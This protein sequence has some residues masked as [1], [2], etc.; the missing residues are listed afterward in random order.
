VQRP[1]SPIV[2][3]PTLLTV[4]RFQVPIGRVA[5]DRA[6]LAP[7]P[8]SPLADLSRLRPSTRG[9]II[10]P[11]V[12]S[13][14]LSTTT[15][16]NL[17]ANGLDLN[18]RNANGQTMVEV[19]LK[20]IRPETAAFVAALRA[21][22]AD[23]AL[24]DSQGN[25]LLHREVMAGNIA[26]VGILLANRVDVNAFNIT[27]SP[28]V[29]SAY[30]ASPEIVRGTMNK[31]NWI[32]TDIDQATPLHLAVAFSN[33]PALVQILL[34]NGADLNLSNDD[35]CTPLSWAAMFATN[36]EV[37]RVLLR[38]GANVHARG[39]DGAVPLH[40]AAAHSTNPEIINA[41]IEGG[42]QVNAT[43]LA[44]WTS[45]HYAANSSLTPEIIRSL[46]RH[47]ADVR[48]YADRRETPLHLAAAHS[49][50]PQVISALIEGGAQVNATDSEQMTPLHYAAQKSITPG[51]IRSLL[52][53]GANVHAQ[54][55]A[56]ALPLHLAAAD[57]TQPEIINALI[58]IGAQVNATD[59]EG[60]T[61]LHWA[62]S[63]SITPNVIR[64]LLRHGANVH[65]QS[66]AGT[67][68]LHKAAAYST[69][70]EIINIL[71]EGG[72]H[73]NATN[74]EQAT[75]LHFAASNSITPEIIRSLLQH[76]ADVDARTDGGI[77]PLHLAAGVAT[78]PAV[79][80]ALV[81]GGAQINATDLAHWT[82]LHYA[83]GNL[84][85]PE[86]VRALLRHGADVH[87]RDDEAS[88]PLHVAAGISTKLE[89]ISALI[90]GGAQIN[91]ANLE[92]RTPLHTAAN[93]SIT[94]EVI[95]F[96]LHH[97][98]DINAID[99]NGDSPLKLAE[100]REEPS[101]API[102]ALLQAAQRAN[103]MTLIDGVEFPFSAEDLAEERRLQA[104]CYPQLSSQ[105]LPAVQ[106]AQPLQTSTPSPAQTT[107]QLAPENQRPVSTR[108]RGEQSWRLPPNPAGQVAEPGAAAFTQ[109]LQR[110]KGGNNQLA[111]AEFRNGATKPAFV[112]RVDALL[113]AIEV[114]PA[115]RKRCL[116]IANDAT[117]TCGDRVALALND[118][119]LAK[120]V[121][122]A[123]SGFYTASELFTLGRGMYRLKLLDEVVIEK[124]VRLGMPD[125]TAED[126]E[127]RL[128]Y[129][130]R[131]ADRLVLPGVAK[132]MLFE[133][134]AHLSNAD[135]DQAFNDVKRKESQ[136]SW[137]E[138]LMNWTP[139]QKVLERENPEGYATRVAHL[140]ETNA[141]T[142]STLPDWMSTQDQMM[143][144]E[145]AAQLRAQALR[146]FVMTE[147]DRFWMENGQ[148]LEF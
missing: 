94:P 124:I 80:S 143:F 64:S 27:T 4:P 86:I 74:L 25:T 22:G 39:V 114:S 6:R 56:G 85:T 50:R 62:A 38:H 144:Y 110:L 46:L 147:T 77:S 100:R 91:A 141:E 134:Y 54:N 93:K 53:H 113:D 133:S 84:V 125:E 48:A 97:G 13:P 14:V 111:P 34:Q 148:A 90:D 43:N 116:A 140:L 128:A 49:I 51:V 26:S 108:P 75:P 73:V 103:P 11:A 18:A 15:I 45:L 8:P 10:H 12:E 82:P 67:M 109:F 24:P 60:T 117:G 130:M 118:M 121:E 58:E 3:E 81:D 120:I 41:L 101:A 146:A 68:P 20:N 83:A 55:I 119:E 98:G 106:E 89:G 123:Q 107:S 5:P 21:E 135:I 9:G 63:K 127:I 87:A 104:L 65:A 19:A 40:I 57:S 71:I 33:A 138:F 129:Q 36:P 69:Q 142:Y 132:A 29:I 76:G 115:L 92:Q 42:A 2:A 99:N 66:T 88:L 52:R 136:G 59:S 70:P 35:H 32:W 137:R 31:A 17:V 47:G 131:L 23:L 126:I 145:Q 16:R 95:R 112:A 37:V 102:I 78:K 30:A 28:P 79:I 61:P 139:W 1:P 105:P 7:R 72:A 122:D 96:L 44:R